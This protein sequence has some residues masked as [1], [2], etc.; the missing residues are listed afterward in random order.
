RLNVAV[1]RAKKKIY[2]V[3]SLYPEE[4]KVDDLISTGP[5]LLKDFMRYCYFVSGKNY[6]MAKAVLNQLY[7]SETQTKTALSNI[8]VKDIKQR[9]ERNGYEVEESIGIGRYKISLGIRDPKTKSYMLGI[10]CDTQNDTLNARRDLLHQEKY[11][12]SRNWQIYRVFES[13]WYT[14]PNR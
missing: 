14:N 6:E 3:S 5:K 10:I 4:F 8:M 11:L 12:K 7:T 13:N 1:T 9:L 2:F